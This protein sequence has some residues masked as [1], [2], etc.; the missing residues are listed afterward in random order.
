MTAFFHCKKA[1]VFD[2]AT[3]Q[4]IA[5][6]VSVGPM[7]SLLVTLPRSFKHSSADPVQVV[8]YD[9]VEG[10]VTCRC[11][12]SAPLITDDRQHCS[13]RCQVLDRLSQE[14]RREDI[15]I[16]LTSKVTVTLETPERTLEAPATIYNISA[17]GIYMAVTD[18]ELNPGDQ[19]SFYFH[20]AGGTIPLTAEVLRVEVRRDRYSRPVKGYGCQFVDLAAM[21]ELQLRGFVFK[22]ARRFYQKE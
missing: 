14:Q 2:K 19:V 17:G 6:A 7:D 8:F 22:E 16:P 12:L 13:Y 3:G 9:P 10:L 1:E 5:A 15:K 4:S 11:T 20:D 21:Y 18:L